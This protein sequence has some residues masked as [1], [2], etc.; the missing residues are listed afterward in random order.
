MAKYCDQCGKPLP[1]GVEICPD[2][3]SGAGEEAALFTRMTAETE[4]WKSTE[5]VKQSSHLAK[6]VRS[7]RSRIILYSGAVVLAALAVFLI[8]FSQPA[9][10]VTRTLNRGEVEQAYELFWS[11]PRL[12]SGERTEK[13]DRAL[14]AAAERLCVQYADHEIDADSAAALL[15]KLGGF[16]AGAAE[17]LEPTYA[18]FRSYNGSQLRM[19]EAEKLFSDGE[20]LAAREAYLQVDENDA[21]YPDALEKADECLVR[22]GESVGEE[23]DALMAENQYL[24]AMDALHTGNDTL[25]ALDTFS[26][27]IDSKLLE[28]FD[29]YEQFILKEAKSLA[30]AQDFDGALEQI[31][32]G[33]RGL[34]KETESLRKAEEEYTALAREKRIAD[35]EAQANALYAEGSFAE[36]FA[37]LDA[38]CAEA[39]ETE[40]APEKLLETT[41]ARFITEFSD[42]AKA[43]SDTRDTLPDAIAILDE[44][45]E[46][47]E[48]EALQTCREELA[49]YLPLFL[50]EAEYSAKD[51][52]VFRNDS[53][54]ESLDGTVYG[55]GWMWGEDGAEI[56]FDL[57]GGYDEFYCAFAMRRNDSANANGWFEVFCD[58]EQVLK[59]DK[60]YHWQKDPKYYQ[61]EIS[62]CEELKVVFHCDYKTST[63][64]NGYCYHGL[65]DIQVTKDM[66][67]APKCE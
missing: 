28:C 53:G 65:C 38:L 63:A 49:Q 50:A 57:D 11:S 35:A 29:R 46:I 7:N 40:T 16:G 64:E 42:R 1:D 36:A 56:S 24:E 27:V 47:R 32:S 10:R 4:V 51:G 25:Y 6:K 54:F 52:T 44:A 2:C 48:L 22:Y 59:A 8:L 26:E 13:L 43:L 39:D 61:V 19:D 15:S 9:A 20:Y 41:E 5:P 14:L 21:S 3:G 33:M 12:A 67:S 55:G 58:G 37:V 62:G 17:L 31:R 23:A 34:D 66:A 30:E 60:L 18:R 45:L